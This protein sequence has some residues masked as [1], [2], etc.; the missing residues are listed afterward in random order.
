MTAFDRRL[1]QMEARVL[2]LLYAQ[3]VDL[4]DLISRRIH[5]L[6]AQVEADTPRKI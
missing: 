6:R 3:L 1:V 4:A 5:E 2:A